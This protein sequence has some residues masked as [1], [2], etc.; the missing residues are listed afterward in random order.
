MC[1]YLHTSTRICTH[2]AL[3]C[4]HLHALTRTCTHL[5]GCA[6]G[7]KT[8]AQHDAEWFIY[9]VAVPGL[10][11]ACVGQDFESSKLH[12][13]DLCRFCTGATMNTQP[14][15]AENHQYWKFSTFPTSS[16]S[17]H[18]PGGHLAKV[19]YPDTNISIWRGRSDLSATYRW[20]CLQHT[21][22]IVSHS[23]TTVCIF[24]T[25]ALR[26]VESRGT[27]SLSPCVQ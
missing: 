12:C 8:C 16:G 17:Y 24:R 15:L 2:L 26:V 5:H 19:A 23:V 13:Q 21:Q 10:E 22:G 9:V 25:C 14:I 3:T 4:T 7:K 27:P 11:S 1:T 20:R 6:T 18:R